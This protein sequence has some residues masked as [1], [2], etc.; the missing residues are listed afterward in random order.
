MNQRKENG[1]APY[2]IA[3]YSQVTANTRGRGTQAG[4]AAQQAVQEGNS[5]LCP[6]KIVEVNSLG[7]FIR[8]LNTSP[9]Q[10]IDIGGYILRQLEG[11]HAISM[12]RFPQNLLISALQHITVWAS[13]AKISHNPPT[14]LVWKGRLYFRS[15]PKCITVLSRPNNQP[16]ASYKTE[17]SPYLYTAARPSVYQNQKLTSQLM[18]E[19]NQS[20]SNSP[21][22]ALPRTCGVSAMPYRHSSITQS[23]S[24]VPGIGQQ[25]PLT[26]RNSGLICTDSP[27]ASVTWRPLRLNI[28]S[29]LVRLVVQKT[30]R[31][32]HGFNYLSHIPFTFDLLKV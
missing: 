6:L 19:Q 4:Q 15:S 16:V 27:P 12:Y 10:D 11:E 23:M 29:P 17:D 14:D 20:N 31:S 30:A 32:K 25:S 1:L 18:T 28:N 21:S 2:R 3:H 7:Y 9:H 26:S 24:Y 22:P 5:S 8:I 13:A